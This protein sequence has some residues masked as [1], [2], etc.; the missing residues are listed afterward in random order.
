M[1]LRASLD[2]SNTCPKIDR[3]ISATK[4]GLRRCLAEFLEEACPLL[5][6]S[7][8]QFNRVVDSWFYRSFQLIEP[9]FEAVRSTNEDM[10][11]VADRQIS[12]LTDEVGNL[13]AEV[14]RFKQEAA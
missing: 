3:E 8:D 2:Y 14:E 6:L 11:R 5:L 4:D 10:R 9:S 12:D 7:G 1:R 13:Q